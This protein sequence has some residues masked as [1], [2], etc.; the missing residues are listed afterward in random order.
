MDKRRKR[1]AREA[2]LMALQRVEE[3]GAF[4]NLALA[5][6]LAAAPMEQRDKGL[7][8]EI[9]Y[10]VI[11]HRLTLDWMISQVAAR[12]VEKIDASLLQILRIGFYQLFYL[13]RIPA[14][15]AVYATVELAKKGKKKGLAPFVNGVLRGA[16]R[17]KD[18]LPWPERSDDESAYLALRHA[19]P[20]WLVKRWLA[21][22]GS[23]ETEEL[24]QANNRPAPLTARVNTLLTT[25]EGLLTSLAGEGV[26]AAPS[27]AAPEGVIFKTGGRLTSLAAYR[28]GL[29][30]VQG[31]SAMFAA[32]ILAPLPGEDVLDCCS[33]PGGKTTHLAQLMEN[34]GKVLALDIYPHRLALVEA[35][36][37]RLR[38]DN[39]RTFCLD[40]REID[41]LKQG[42]FDRILLDVPC[43]G[44][45]VLRRKPDLKWR[46]EEKDIFELAQLQKELVQAALSVLKPGGAMLYCTCTNEPEETEEVVAHTLLNNRDLSLGELASSLPPQCQA[47]VGEF[48]VHLLPQ[49][50]RLDGFFFSLL[51]KR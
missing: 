17:Q 18:S 15:A 32:R 46:I 1:D 33:A 34:Q 27:L 50:H 7:A 2:S 36:C 39:V 9:T 44:L 20:Q 30:Q 40:A 28:Q 5:E 8:T 4:V 31:E 42:F 16:L 48:G 12:P 19:H 49:R 37:R 23:Q 51:K 3:D 43:S 41:P 38:V 21:Q 25:R 26:E 35:N 47:G 29:F 14:S 22:Y 45:G 11:T 13:N 24:L 6:V 10:G